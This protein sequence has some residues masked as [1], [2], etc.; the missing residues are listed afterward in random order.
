MTRHWPSN[1]SGGRLP[2]LPATACVAHSPWLNT[3]AVARSSGLQAQRV[4]KQSSPAVFCEIPCAPLGHA[5]KISGRTITVM[6]SNFP[7]WMKVPCRPGWKLMLASFSCK[8]WVH[9]KAP[10]SNR[11]CELP[12]SEQ[13]KLIRDRHHKYRMLAAGKVPLPH[14]DIHTILK[15]VP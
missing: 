5:S 4:R 12:A 14:N 10:S 3:C 7:A 9:G 8:V 11:L 15:S 13:A 1:H 6:L 2:L